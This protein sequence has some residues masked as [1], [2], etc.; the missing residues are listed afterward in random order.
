[1][2]QA[3]TPGSRASMRARQSRTTSSQVASP[4]V[5]ARTISVAESLLRSGARVGARLGLGRAGHGAA[6]FRPARAAAVPAIR[7]NT[8]PEVSPEPPG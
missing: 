2:A 6:Q 7:P 3:C 8:A 5:V 1:M 4:A